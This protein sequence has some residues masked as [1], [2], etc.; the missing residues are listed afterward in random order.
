MDHFAASLPAFW[1]V[2]DFSWPVHEEYHQIPNLMKIYVNSNGIA[3]KFHSRYTRPQNYKDLPMIL[4]QRLV[5]NTQRSRRTAHE[6]WPINFEQ[7]VWRMIELEK[8]QQIK[9]LGLKT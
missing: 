4:G 3:Q 2:F 8:D 5:L 1:T 7:A 6:T 9:K